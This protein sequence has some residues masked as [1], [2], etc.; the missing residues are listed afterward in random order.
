VKKSGGR[1]APPAVVMRSGVG[2]GRLVVF[3]VRLRGLGGVVRSVL[4]MAVREVRV[5][6]GCFMLAVFVVLGGF[7][8]MTSRVLVML[9]CCVMVFCCHF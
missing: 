6:R 5:M 1:A 9:G 3:D 4:M 7:L 8:V 2:C